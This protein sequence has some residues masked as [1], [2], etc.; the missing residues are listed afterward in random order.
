[1]DKVKE[2]H[3]S[4]KLIARKDIEA[5]FVCIMSDIVDGVGIGTGVCGGNTQNHQLF[6]V[7]SSLNRP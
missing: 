6:S 4:D 2:K 5:C 1:M 7:H 3:E